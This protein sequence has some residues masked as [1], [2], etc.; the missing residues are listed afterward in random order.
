MI[1]LSRFAQNLGIMY[2]SGIP[3]LEALRVSR[4]FVG[5]RAY[6]Q[7]LADIEEGVNQGEPIHARMRRHAIFPPMV[8]QM[9]EVGEST[10]TLADGLQSVCDYFENLLP[11]TIG[12]EVPEPEKQM[13]PQMDAD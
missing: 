10:G 1:C 5:N 6:E 4:T 11:R 2:R 3:L 9:I 12:Y 8:Q 7:S 13:Q